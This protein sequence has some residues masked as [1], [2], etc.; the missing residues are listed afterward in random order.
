[1]L[2]ANRVDFGLLFF[3]VS[4]IVPFYSSPA[5]ATEYQHFWQEVTLA[6]DGL[7]IAITA[8]LPIPVGVYIIFI[9][10]SPRAGA[11]KHDCVDGLARYNLVYLS[12]LVWGG[13]QKAVHTEL[14]DK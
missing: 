1:M 9:F 11:Y 14:E 2:S 5:A 13:T 8:P 4:L 6:I 3:F 10:L 12:F 7:Q